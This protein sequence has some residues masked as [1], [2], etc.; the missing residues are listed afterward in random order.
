M[1][2][3]ACCAV[4]RAAAAAAP[5]HVLYRTA[6]AGRLRAAGMDGQTAHAAVCVTEDHIWLAMDARSGRRGWR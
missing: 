4:L 5:Y 3:A 2:R 6:A 1:V